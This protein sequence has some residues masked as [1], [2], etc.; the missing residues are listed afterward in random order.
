[1]AVAVQTVGLGA[2]VNQGVSTQ[3]VITK[4]TGLAVGDLMVAH[5]FQ[6]DDSGDVTPPANWT[7]VRDDTITD[8]ANVARSFLWWKVADSGDV[9]ASNFTFTGVDTDGVRGG[10]IYRIDGQHVETPIG[11]DNGT[12]INN[13]GTP[14]Y[15]ITITPTAD[16]LILIFTGGQFSATTVSAYAIATSNPSWTEGYDQNSGSSNDYTM[17]SAY[18]VRPESTATGNATLTYADDNGGAIDT[19]G[20]ILAIAPRVDVSV[21]TPLYTATLYL[22]TT[23]IANLLNMSVSLLTHSAHKWTAAGKTVA[24]TFS[25]TSKN[26]ISPTNSSKNP[27]SPSNVAKS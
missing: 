17:A 27:I 15:A 26:S 7:A 11:E 19:A 14:D 9:A 5:V 25:N 18:A 16:N 12:T 1:M 6:G 3:L 4:P 10:A 13:D 24:A 20:Q 8:G 22:F 2:F 23:A 21:A